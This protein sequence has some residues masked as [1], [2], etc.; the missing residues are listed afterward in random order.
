[1]PLVAQ[2]IGSLWSLMIFFL[3]SCVFPSGCEERLAPSGCEERLAPEATERSSTATRRL[4][5]GECAQFQSLEQ[6]KVLSCCYSCCCCC[7]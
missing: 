5:Q 4:S 2:P 1:M 6:L 7:C 3:I